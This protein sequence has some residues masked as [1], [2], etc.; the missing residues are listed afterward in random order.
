MSGL[1]EAISGAVGE[2]LNEAGGF[3]FTRLTSPWLTGQATAFVESTFGWPASGTF[4]SSG[5]KYSYTS[6]GAYFLSGITYTVGATPVVGAK[7]D[8]A[9][10]TRLLDWSKT[11]S[12]VDNTIQNLFVGTATGES[13]SIVGRNLGV[14][15]PPALDDD[16]IF[17]E[18]IKAIA[19]APKGTI[20]ALE[21]ALTAFFGA[22]N[23]L[24]WENF[25]QKNNTVYIRI[26]GNL[27]LAVVATG[28]AYLTGQ[29]NR[30]L[31]VGPQ[32]I[33]ITLPTPSM[34]PVQG[35]R[36][37]PEAKETL[38]TGAAKP[39]AGHLDVRY[40]G[41][42]GVQV[43]TFAG[44]S[45][46]ADVLTSTSDGGCVRMLDTVAAN[47]AAYLHT[48]R[49]RPESNAY[50]ELFVRP[51]T[52]NG[53]TASFQMQLADGDEIIC[54][55][56]IRS[57]A[58]TTAVGFIDSSTGAF[59]AGAGAILDNATY[60]SVAIRKNGRG[61]VELLVN[62]SIVQTQALDGSFASTVLNE[63]RFGCLSALAGQVGSE[64][65]IK[66][67]SYSAVTITDYW[68]IQGTAGAST[69]IAAF[70]TNSGD[71]VPA[72][73]V[74]KSFRTF[75]AA[76]PVNNGSWL[77]VTVPD[78]DNVTL[79]GRQQQLAI[80]ESG[81]PSRIRIAGNARAFKFPDDVGKR[82]DLTAASTAPNPGT[83]VISQIL[84]PVLLTPMT[85]ILVDYSNVVEV[86]ASPGFVTET[87]IPWKL[88][89][90]FTVASPIS[91]ELSN[92]GSV[93]GF[94]LTLREN[95]PL[96]IPGGYVVIMEV[97]YSAIPSAQLVS[98][99]EVVNEFV[100]GA[101]TYHPFYLPSNPLGPFEAF[102]DDLTV[103][104]VIP[105][106]SF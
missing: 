58:S 96:D 13:L 25:S 5:V 10:E 92:A 95:P 81:N 3:R 64:Y 41:D 63:V 62:G 6:K 49:V 85:G 57:T 24:I 29:V 31:A 97:V 69:G 102:L 21:L 59:L 2:A 15:R 88:L 45:E 94:T 12:A 14:K 43:W 86:T 51:H 36:L 47:T 42:A 1:L 33:T 78:T 50:F 17:R 54:V 66:D 23:F 40:T 103:A 104:G 60:Y 67:A 99:L 82:I 48:M 65:R 106:V 90:N 19:Y 35:V 38:F 46:A 79:T 80:V 34:P 39:S 89:P 53:T 93:S 101:Y 28:Q 32:T 4:F 22:G 70:D 100:S 44:A 55:G 105:E 8:Y 7:A 37:A 87:E 71:M 18:V 27:F 84:D 16:D 98:G 68:N 52:S 20:Y 74:G 91:W 11:F 72:S 73:D 9:V 26:T 30:P 56:F 83:Y 75:D 61:G 77:T 76:N